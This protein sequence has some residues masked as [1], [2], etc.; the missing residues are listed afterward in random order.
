MQN[1]EIELDAK[2]IVDLIEFGNSPNAS[3]SSLLAD[4]RSLLDRIPLTRVKHVYRE[5]NRCADA[6]AR[7]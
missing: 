7:K 1:L 6:L 2:I 4:Y 5:A 3:Y